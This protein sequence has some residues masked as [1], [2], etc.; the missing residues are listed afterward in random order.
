[1]GR[2]KIVP[3]IQ[4][5]L[6]AL[7]LSTVMV[8]IAS[9]ST[10]KTISLSS[11]SGSVT[12]QL[13]DEGG[14]LRYSVHLD[15]KMIV[16]ESDVGIQSDGIQYGKNASLG[17]EER[18]EIN[19]T[20]PFFGG[21]S[22]AINQANLV[23]VPVV[24][25]GETYWVDLHVA[26]DGTA[27]R[28][29]LPAKPGRKIEAELSTWKIP[30]DPQAWYTPYD[31]GYEEH[32]RISSFKR[33]GKQN[34]GLPMTFKMREGYVALAEAAIV[35]YGDLGI[36]LENDGVLAGYLPNDQKGWNTDNQVVQ[37][38]RVTIVARDLTAL[39]NT[40][41]V[42]NLNPP[43][44]PKLLNAD[45]IKPGRSTWQWM[46]IGGPKFDDQHEW[47][48]WTRS[49]GYEYYLIDDGWAKWKDKWE[50]LKSVVDYAKTQNVKIWLWVDSKEVFSPEARRD[51]FK[52]AVDTGIVGV[53][54]DFPKATNRQWSL[55]YRDC[56]QDAA[57]NQLLINFHGASKPSGMERTYPNELTREA[58]RGHE[59]HITRYNRLMEPQQ[60]TLLPFTRYLIGHGDY[61]PMVF[62]SKELQGNS[63]AHEI[64]QSVVFTS[65]FLCTGGHPRDYVNSPAKDVI[66]ALP[67]T[68]DETIVLPSTVPG[69]IVAIARRSGDQWFVGVMTGMESTTIDIPLSFLGDGD[70]KIT[71]L[72]DVL[73]K[74]DAFDRSDVTGNT[75][76]RL[77]VPMSSRGGFV[78]WIRK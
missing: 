1:M 38:W 56:A 43:A 31:P 72:G 22:K 73:G 44:D 9:Q 70:W 21:K 46:A 51:Y 2:R 58:V 48:D 61:T 26:D 34:Y 69:K 4:K 47:V 57:D 29:R 20:Y 35:D 3:G 62:E 75:K 24:T 67:A 28:M 5:M 14:Q 64:A 37:P 8:G 41:L 45:W 12:M 68:W 39:V 23:T 74:A 15:G 25:N 17:N 50:S 71:R 16:S 11:P 30:G 42:Q 76:T 7:A 53:K 40:T 19:E 27:I 52:K 6:R 18:K 54:V 36:K 60:D 13:S 63:W 33:L 55:W 49:L 59:Y 65:P 78:A 77:H 66:S 10:A 32:Y